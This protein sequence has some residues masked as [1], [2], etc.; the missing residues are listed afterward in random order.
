MAGT[1]I[2]DE[3]NSA[4]VSWGWF[5]DGFRPSTSFSAAL[6]AT[7]ETG[8]ATSTFI[9]DE[10]KSYFATA[11]N[12]PA[13]SSNQGLCD[14]VHPIGLALGGTGQ[15]G[16]KDDYMP[17]RAITSTTTSPTRPRSSTSSSTTGACRAFPARPTRFWPVSTKRKEV[18]FDLAGMFDFKDQPNS[19]LILDPSTG[20]YLCAR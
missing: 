17:R 7:G 13:H 6:T 3:L 12:R 2:G 11:A 10:F 9:P 18:P 1:N 4:G 20:V 16:Y 5:E 15:H 14:S 8:Q 19:K